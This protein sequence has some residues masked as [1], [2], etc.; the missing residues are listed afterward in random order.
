[1]DRLTLDNPGPLCEWAPDKPG[2][3]PVGWRGKF[4][5][6]VKGDGIY[7]FG[8]TRMLKEV[9][10]AASIL[11]EGHYTQRPYSTFYDVLMAYDL[12]IYALPNG[13]YRWIWRLREDPSN[14]GMGLDVLGILHG[15]FNIRV[16]GGVRFRF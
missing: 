4:K 12:R 14:V 1:M 3:G 9:K 11:S 10:L 2:A 6:A 5:Q 8:S 15:I 7:C 16:S 13:G